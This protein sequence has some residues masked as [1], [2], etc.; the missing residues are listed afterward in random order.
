[1]DYAKGK[2][3]LA[4][5][6]L[7]RYIL[8]YKAYIYRLIK[9]FIISIKVFPAVFAE[10]S[11]YG[12][13]EINFKGDGVI[14]TRPKI[15]YGE[16]F[17]LA[18]SKA[19]KNKTSK[20]FHRFHYCRHRA[21]LYSFGASIAQ[22]R[23]PDM[24]MVECGVWYGLLANFTLERFKQRGINQK[25]NLIDLFGINTESYKVIGEKKKEYED[26]SIYKA[27][28]ERF[29][30]HNVKIHQ[31][32]IPDVF[33]SEAIRRINH[34]SFLS[35][36]LNNVKAE[37][38]AFNYFEPKM[39]I[40]G[41]LYIDDYGCQGYESTKEFYDIFFKDKFIPL[42]SLHSSCLAIKVKN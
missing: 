33:K 6:R 31:G 40:G 4:S 30:E 9:A 3:N 36:D 15:S 27:V 39:P 24:E 19:L 32:F 14:S 17:E 2:N 21:A 20:E 7:T 41:I 18:W 35:C 10:P 25:F 28:Q 8:G 34:V 22:N 13:G 16:S 5:I 29:S 23:F 38:D 37:T 11:S 1:M 42:K 26:Q 12:V